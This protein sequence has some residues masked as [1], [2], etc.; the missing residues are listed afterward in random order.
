MSSYP[1][2]DDLLAGVE[3]YLKEKII[4]SLTDPGVRFRTRIAAHLIGTARREL[5]FGPQNATQELAGLNDLKCLPPPPMELQSDPQRIEWLNENLAQ[6]LQ[7]GDI[8]LD[9]HAVFSHLV[10]T[11]GDQLNIVQPRFDQG[12]HCE[13][14][15]D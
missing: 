1:N 15:S 3:Q 7:L 13:S 9:D 14:S 2:A 5:E 6:R 10:K 12:L 8:P 11:L 4:P